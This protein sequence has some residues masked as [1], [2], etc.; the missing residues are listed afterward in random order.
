MDFSILEKRVGVKFEDRSFLKQALTH[1]SWLNENR[2]SP[3]GHNERLEFLGD[4]VLELIVKEFLFRKYPSTQEGLLTAYKAGLV[5]NTVLSDTAVGLGLGDFLLMSRGEAKDTGRARA[6]ILANTFE[7]IVGALYL[8][9]GYEGAR[10]FVAQFLLPKM[11]GI[12]EN[13]LWRDPKS[14]LQEAAQEHLRLTPTYEVL[15]ENGP[16]HER[17]FIVGVY[18]GS[19]LVA[20]GQGGAKQLAEADAAKTALALKGWAQSPAV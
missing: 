9:Q 1:R 4:A 3:L 20:Q 7:A 12:V 6:Q 17:Q 2:A 18:F 15:E 13:G 5:N 8:D 11:Q 16:D 14:Q 19:D 10:R